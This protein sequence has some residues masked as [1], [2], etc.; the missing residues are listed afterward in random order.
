MAVPRNRALQNESTVQRSSSP[1]SV[2]VPSRGIDDYGPTAA[3]IVGSAENQ[4]DTHSCTEVIDTYKTNWATATLASVVYL[5]CCLIIYHDVLKLTSAYY[6]AP[7][8]HRGAKYGLTIT[9]RLGVLKDLLTQWHTFALAHKWQ[10]FVF[11][12]LLLSVFHGGELLWFDDDADLHVT[13][14]SLVKAYCQGNQHT[15][16]TDEIQMVCIQSDYQIMH[17]EHVSGIRLEVYSDSA[18]NLGVEGVPQPCTVSGVPISCPEDIPAWLSA[19]YHGNY[20]SLIWEHRN[21]GMNLAVRVLI[22]M[23][24]KVAVVWPFGV[25]LGNARQMLLAEA[26]SLLFILF[27]MNAYTT[28]TNSILHFVH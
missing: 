10:Y 11:G 4:A 27:G 2:R 15:A 20:K 25:G 5:A 1:V 9:Q 16:L 26:A 28:D 8:F 21:A 22:L 6:G 3:T 17:L 19:E 24:I 7:K 18:W 12:G 14:D 13:D 23:A